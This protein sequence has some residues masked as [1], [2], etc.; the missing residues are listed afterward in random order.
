MEPF[1]FL[2]GS[3]NLFKYLFTV[4]AVMII[5]SIF[6]PLQKSQEIEIKQTDLLKESEL[7]TNEIRLLKNDYQILKDEYSDIS[8]ILDS[9]VLVH[10]DKVTENIQFLEYRKKGNKMIQNLNDRERELKIK[11]IIIQN[12]ESK[13]DL[14]GK[15]SE[16]FKSY[17]S[18][19]KW[20][21]IIFLIIG[22][23]G[24]CLSTFVR[25]RIQWIEL[26]Q[27]IPKKEKTEPS[28]NANEPKNSDDKLTE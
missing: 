14:L 9:L 7:L 1:S 17:Y 12:E 28:K 3:D 11:N 15:H 16:S 24:W 19:V 5:I 10:G 20:L 13:I 8:H 2:S 6:Y 26:Q 22:F 4:G 21:G 25:E 27:K 23:I 18:L